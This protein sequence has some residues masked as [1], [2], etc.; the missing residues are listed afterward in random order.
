[1]PGATFSNNMHNKDPTK[2]LATKVIE[3][4]QKARFWL[5][6]FKSAID[7]QAIGGI[8]CFTS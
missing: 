3:V 2:L 4:N 8:K 1:M 7:V 5:I 6:K